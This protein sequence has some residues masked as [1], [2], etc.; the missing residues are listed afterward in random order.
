MKTSEQTKQQLKKWEG[1]KLFAYLDTGGVPTIG[2][3]HTKN[4][5]LGDAITLEQAERFFD[6]DLTIFENEV[7]RINRELPQYQFDALVS[8]CYNVGISAFR[9]STLRRYVE[10][11]MKVNY[12]VKEFGRWIYDNGQV[13]KGLKNRRQWEAQKY[14]GNI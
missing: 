14:L 12:V 4:V 6:E 9:R 11:G 5:E 3:G 7:N 10:M 1:L 13:I 2:Y 8:F